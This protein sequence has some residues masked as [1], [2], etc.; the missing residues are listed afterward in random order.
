VSGGF[1]EAAAAAAAAPF[2]SA[3]PIPHTARSAANPDHPT[4]TIYQ[5][6]PMARVV[7][8]LRPL[9]CSTCVASM[10]RQHARAIA[11]P[12]SSQLART[13]RRLSSSS[14]SSST[15]PTHTAAQQDLSAIREVVGARAPRRV[16]L[17]EVGPRDG[18]QNEQRFI[19]TAVKAELVDRLSRTG[20]KAIE[21]ASFV[22]PDWVPQVRPRARARR[23]LTGLYSRAGGR[24]AT[25]ARSCR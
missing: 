17:M 20:L 14:S 8:S 7:V 3:P 21:A 16:R 24:C 12:L 19:P 10:L 25:A 9:S 18:L 15:T 1:E 4:I 11:A 13:Q 2:R 5:C 22:R 6:H 23:S